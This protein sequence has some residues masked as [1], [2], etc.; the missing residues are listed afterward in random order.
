LR[1]RVRGVAVYDDFAHHPTA[2]RETL[3]ALRAVA[4]AGRL[5]AVFEPR[6]YTSRTRTFQEAFAQAFAEAD[7]VVVAAAHL[8]GKVP[9]A[10]RLSERDLVSGIARAGAEA[11]F[12]PRV[13]E[14]VEHLASWLADGDCVAILSNGGFDAAH[15]RLLAALAPTA[16]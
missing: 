15:E 10:E 4:G 12:I 16:A 2:V 5:V 11:V 1:G 9:E 14:I 13:S 6:S 8:P 3:R 7:Y